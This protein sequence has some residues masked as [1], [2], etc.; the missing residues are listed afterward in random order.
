M[1]RTPG[2]KLFNIQQVLDYWDELV[3]KRGHNNCKN[4][5]TIAILQALI[6]KKNPRKHI[7]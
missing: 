3:Q 1:S 7:S 2:N 6:S 4:Y 5:N